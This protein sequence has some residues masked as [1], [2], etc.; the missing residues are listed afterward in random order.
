[1]S[2]RIAVTPGDHD[3]VGPE[4]ALRLWQAF[5][6]NDSVEFTFVGP[7]NL[8]SRAAEL[9]GVSAQDLPTAEVEVAADPQWAHLAGVGEV[10]T[11]VRG[12]LSGR[13]DALCTGPLHKASLLEQGFPY[14]G[15]TP[16]LAA[17]CARP[18]ED[19]VMV[20]AGGRLTV[21][22][23]TVHVPLSEVPQAL[24]RAGIVRA[25]LGAADVVRMGWGIERPRIAVCGLN[26]HAG[27]GGRLGGE[28]QQVVA[29]AVAALRE[30][31]IDASGPWP[32][33]TVFGRALR[34]DFD[35]VVAAYHDQGLVAVKTLDFGKSVNIT[36]G[37]PVLRTSVD[38]GTARDIAWRGIANADGMLAAARM[39]IRLASSVSAGVRDE[40]K[41]SAAKSP[42]ASSC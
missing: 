14:M 33:D 4:L 34:G 38:H 6:R 19:A 16:Y 36:A 22:L 2:V 7:H 9:V 37:L 30:Q 28:D 5:A 39:A 42:H 21:S 10:A 11:A 31:G 25:A 24:S 29:P 17:L 35:A 23:A 13:F 40:D 32:A 12:C 3:G 27:E 26:P 41:V 15:H 8:W 1:M 20:F 18:C